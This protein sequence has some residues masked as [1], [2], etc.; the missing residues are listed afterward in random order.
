MKPTSLEG[1]VHICEPFFTTKAGEHEG[2][3]LSVACGLLRRH[4][5]ELDLGQPQ[6]QG[7]IVTLRLPEMPKPQA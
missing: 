6:E 4:G 2:L 1:T 7:A 3:G 5:G